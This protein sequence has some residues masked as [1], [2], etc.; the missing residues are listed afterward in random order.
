MQVLIISAEGWF[1]PDKIKGNHF[2]YYSLVR[3]ICALQNIGNTHLIPTAVQPALFHYFVLVYNLYPANQFTWLSV[4][5]ILLLK[6]LPWVVAGLCCCKTTVPVQE[7]KS[8]G[9]DCESFLC[10]SVIA[11]QTRKVHTWICFTLVIGQEYILILSAKSVF[12]G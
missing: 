1:R 8:L 10:L 3:L 2:V 9:T 12:T 11:I 5:G 7:S 6:T 4:R